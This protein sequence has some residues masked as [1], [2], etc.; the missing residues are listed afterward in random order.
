M[1]KIITSCLIASIAFLPALRA[2]QPKFQRV[3]NESSSPEVQP[4]PPSSPTGG[5]NDDDSNSSHNHDQESPSQDENPSQNQHPDDQ[6]STSHQI[7][8][9][10]IPSLEAASPDFDQ[11]DEEE[12]QGTPVGQ[13]SNEGFNAAK[14]KQWRNITIAIVAVAVAATALLLIANNDGHHRKHD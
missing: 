14:S 3:S 5:S 2:Q 9:S 1:K 7:P 6:E 10:H 8:P 4:A 12:Y 13:A 11:S